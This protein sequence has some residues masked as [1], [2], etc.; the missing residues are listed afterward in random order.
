MHDFLPGIFAKVDFIVYVFKKK[1]MHK[2]QIWFHGF[3]L[4][5]GL[6]MN[7]VETESDRF[8]TMLFQ[9]D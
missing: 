4:F 5:D 8:F 9:Q 2:F 6:C 7:G 3:L 1:C